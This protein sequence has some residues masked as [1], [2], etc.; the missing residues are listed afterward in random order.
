MCE[1][2]TD[3]L[4]LLHRLSLSLSLSLILSII[5]FFKIYFYVLHLCFTL[6][7]HVNKEFYL[8]RKILIYI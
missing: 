1:Y 8:N 6:K 5:V 7:S 2:S 3:T 4:V